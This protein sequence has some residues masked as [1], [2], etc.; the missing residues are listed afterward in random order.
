[1][2]QLVNKLRLQ[3]VQKPKKLSITFYTIKRIPSMKRSYGVSEWFLLMKVTISVAISRRFL[4]KCFLI[5]KLLQSSHRV[6]Q[7]VDTLLYMVKLLNSKE[8]CIMMLSLYHFSLFLLTRVWITVVA[9]RLAETKYFYSQFLRRPTGQSLFDNLN[10]SM[11]ELEK[12]KLLQLA[13]DGPNVN[14]NVLDLLDDKF[15]SDNFSKTLNISSCAQHTVIYHIF[16]APSV[17]AGKL[18]IL[19]CLRE[20][21]FPKKVTKFSIYEL[22]LWFLKECYKSKISF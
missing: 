15:I 13:M 10:E 1:M 8:F 12:N 16:L 20:N 14:W 19:P 6:K 21:P 5:V 18:K 4:K 17:R 9:V 7:R 3:L 11:G 22:F 2:V